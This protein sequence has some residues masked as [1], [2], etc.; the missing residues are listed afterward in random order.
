MKHKDGST[1]IATKPSFSCDGEYPMKKSNK[2]SLDKAL[3]D[4]LRPL[5]E[6]QEAELEFDKH[7]REN[8]LE[9]QFKNKNKGRTEIHYAGPRLRRFDA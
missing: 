3:K 9:A 8:Q 7:F 4:R 2:A 5:T 6:H 1:D